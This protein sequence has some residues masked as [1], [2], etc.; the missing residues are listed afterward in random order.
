MHL[1]ERRPGILQLSVEA[2]VCGQPRPVI[3]VERVERRLGIAGSTSR[4]DEAKGDYARPDGDDK[5]NE[6]GEMP[7][8]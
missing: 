3:E 1:A 4:L 7:A 5:E 2:R 8:T 6:V